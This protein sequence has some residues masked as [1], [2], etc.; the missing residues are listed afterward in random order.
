M[1]LKSKTELLVRI[2]INIIVC[3]FN[4]FLILVSLV[5]SIINITKG[6]YDYI[7]III[8]VPVSLTWVT[9]LQIKQIKKYIYLFDTKQYIDK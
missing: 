5:Y 4:I 3:I 6:V 2:F 7:L 1:E 8:V 9:I